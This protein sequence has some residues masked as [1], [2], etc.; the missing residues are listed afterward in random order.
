M[1]K[2]IAKNNRFDKRLSL[3]PS[4]VLSKIAKIDEFKG[5]WIGGLQINPQ[6]LA[7]LKRSVLVTSTGASTRIEGAKL[8]DKEIEKLMQGVTT[9]KLTDRDSQE[10]HGYYELLHNVFDSWRSIKFSESTVKHFHNQLLKYVEKD[11]RHRGDYKKTEN[12]VE[13]FDQN[14]KS[15]GIVFEPTKA[16]L[17][18]K[19]MQELMD[20]TV[21]VLEE[22]KHHPL[23]IIGN[24]LVEFLKIHPFQDGN[25]RVSR[26]LANLLL[27]KEGYLYM[28]YVSH[29]KLVEDN[30]N[31]YYLALVKSQKTFG[32]KSENIFPWLNFFFDILL[33][34]SETAIKLLESEDVEKL[35]SPKQLDVWNYLQRVPEATPLEICRETKIVK[36]TVVQALNRLVTLKKIERI[37]M[38][39]ATRYRKL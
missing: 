30:K 35:L 13:M 37:G 23:L 33:K 3:I 8:S 28:P 19:E 22:R 38:G 39:R 1:Q 18:P 12:T 17:T 15:I 20:W 27:L 5:R 29:E 26:I 31:N 4:E 24:F 11:Q 16:N 9:K 10:V 34:Q 2:I 32:K 21:Q 36:P 7:R 14:G 6:T 25:G